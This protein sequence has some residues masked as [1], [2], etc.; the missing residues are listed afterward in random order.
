MYEY[1]KGNYVYNGNNYCGTPIR[2]IKTISD[3]EARHWDN[4]EKQIR[5]SK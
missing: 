4:L 3:K 2:E 1:I 5:N